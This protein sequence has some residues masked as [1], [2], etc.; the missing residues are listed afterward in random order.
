[1]VRTKVY[2]Y[3]INLFIWILTLLASVS[4]VPAAH[5]H[6]TFVVVL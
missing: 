5:V 3:Q 2:K 1:M 6:Q 4:G